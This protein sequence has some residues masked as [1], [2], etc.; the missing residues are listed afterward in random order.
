MKKI[1]LFGLVI[2]IVMISSCKDIYSAYLPWPMF[3]GNPQRTG[4][5][6]SANGERGTMDSVKIKWSTS[7]ST[8]TSPAI[9]NIDADNEVE[10]VVGGTDG[11]VYALQGITGQVKWSYSLGGIISTY[12]SSPAL[13]DIDGDS[14]IEVVIGAQNG[15]LYAI[16]GDGSSVDWSKT[17]GDEIS[18]AP[19]IGDVDADTA[20]VEVI[21][22]LKDSTKCLRG[23]DGGIIWAVQTGLSGGMNV[24]S[25]PAI[26]NIDSNFATIEVVVASNDTSVQVLNGVDGSLL[27]RSITELAGSNGTPPMLLFTPAIKDIDNDGT[28]EVVVHHVVGIY[29]F[30]GITGAQRWQNSGYGSL[31]GTAVNEATAL[32]DVDNDGKSEVLIRS[33]A[34]RVLDENF[35]T[36]VW[37]YVFPAD[38]TIGCNPVLADVEGDGKLEVIDANH[39]GWIACLEGED[40]TVK[41]TFNVVS[42]DIHTTHAIGDIDGDGCFEIVGAGDFGPVYAIESECPY[43]IE[44]TKVTPEKI[45][46][47]IAYGENKITVI[48]S[49][50]RNDNM[51]IAVFDICGRQIKRIASGNLTAG[52]YKIS[53]DASDFNNGIYF[54]KVNTINKEL[55]GKIV[56]IK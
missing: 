53:I 37:N 21:I 43:P 1:R 49:L 19:A 11:Y 54:V 6:T 7:V 13:G 40:K 15:V 33:G 10:V 47:K 52:N 55:T 46:L 17:V 51:D 16:K 9:G 27:W 20:T 23:S 35:G 41:W 26:G 25:S 44:E 36:Q 22:G 24:Y 56:I 28:I 2:S 38:A 4:L 45:N 18:S 39:T 42:K 12:C 8:L 5:F 30:D 31:T 3:M 34:V 14:L 29:A 50:C 48:M 32:G